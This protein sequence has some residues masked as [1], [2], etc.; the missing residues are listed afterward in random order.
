MG[1]TSGSSLLAHGGQRIR[2]W[3]H[4]SITI[5]SSSAVWHCRNWG[6]DSTSTTHFSA[7]LMFS[8]IF[9]YFLRIVTA[10]TDQPREMSTNL[11]GEM[12]TNACVEPTSLLTD[13][14]DTHL[15][16]R[17]GTGERQ[18]AERIAWGKEIILVACPSF[19]DNFTGVRQYSLL[20]FSLADSWVLFSYRKPLKGVVFSKPRVLL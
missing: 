9:K 5:I 4:R 17:D 6:N 14:S 13:T 3:G 8:C 7:F 11:W 1:P 19:R 20:S 10:P 16:G 12:L 15:D 18:E 2:E